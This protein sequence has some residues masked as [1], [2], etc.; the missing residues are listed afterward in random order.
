MNGNPHPAPGTDEAP[1]PIHRQTRLGQMDAATERQGH[2][3]PVMDHQLCGLQ[4]SP[5]QQPTPQAINLPGRAAFPTQV[6]LI[7]PQPDFFD[8]DHDVIRRVAIPGDEMK[9]GSDFPF[10]LPAKNRYPGGYR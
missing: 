2:I 6:N 1:H 5:I 3:Q 10:P 4:E 7:H 9:P 8:N